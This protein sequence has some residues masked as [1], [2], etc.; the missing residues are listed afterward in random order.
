MRFDDFITPAC[1]FIDGVEQANST[2]RELL[3]AHNELITEGTL[4]VAQGLKVLILLCALGHDCYLNCDGGFIAVH[5][6]HKPVCHVFDC[7]GVST[8]E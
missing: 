2:L 1:S 7:C 4:K 5:P 6:P 8:V 3:L